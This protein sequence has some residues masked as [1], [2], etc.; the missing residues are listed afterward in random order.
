MLKNSCIALILA[1]SLMT[2]S[3]SPLAAEPTGEAFA[4]TCAAC[5]GT[6]GQLTSET[7]P[8]LAGMSKETFITSMKAFREQ[9]RPSSIMSHI[10][11]G[12]DDRAI[13]Q[14]AE[15]FSKME[16]TKIETKPLA[17]LNYFPGS[18]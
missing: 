6:N 11:N 18:K 4:H 15:F 13:E 17:E 3:Q 12:Y 2:I 14:M 10:A 1:G 5:H 8:P 7:F 16:S 9:S